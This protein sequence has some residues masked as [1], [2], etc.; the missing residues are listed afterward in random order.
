MAIATFFRAMGMQVTFVEQDGAVS[1]TPGQV[2]SIA[3]PPMGS[4][5]APRR[6]S[7]GGG[8]LWMVLVGL[9]VGLVVLAASYAMLLRH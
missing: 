1:A 5:P 7:A 9:A 2:S 8:R 3:P 4:M 6:A